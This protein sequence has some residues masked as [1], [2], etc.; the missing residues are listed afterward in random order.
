[1]MAP[2]L[3]VFVRGFLLCFLR[4]AEVKRHVELCNIRLTGPRVFIL[5]ITTNSCS[6]Q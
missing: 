3:Y 5:T 2:R 6:L 4:D 1:M